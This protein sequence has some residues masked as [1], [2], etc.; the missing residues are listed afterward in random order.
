[1]KID[2]IRVVS[3]C[4]AYKR[5]DLVRSHLAV[6]CGENAPSLVVIVDNGQTLTAEEVAGWAAVPTRLVDPGEN[7]GPAGGFALG[8]DIALASGANLIWLFNDDSRVLPGCLPALQR[9]LV[10]DQRLGIVAPSVRSADGSTWLPGSKRRLGRYVGVDREGLASAEAD[11]VSFNGALVDARVFEKVGGGP[12]PELFM[13]WEEHEFCV[14]VRKA[15]YLIRSMRG[16]QIENDAAGSQG[17]IRPWRAYYQSRNH[18]I[19]SVKNVDAMGL[20]S[21][22]L[23]QIRM[24]SIALRSNRSDKWQLLEARLSGIRDGFAGRTGK[25]V[26]P[27]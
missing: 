2:D 4:V 14:R 9:A 11:V 7:L 26:D 19:F 1:M 6:L 16:A 12:W 22:M 5:N 17:G 3:V 13:M 10:G 15:G 24:I 8:V 21:C 25:T 18:I 23:R 20:M 27:P